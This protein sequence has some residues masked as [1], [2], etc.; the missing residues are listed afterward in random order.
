MDN[1]RVDINLKSG[2]DEDANIPLQLSVR[3]HDDIIVRN[4][5]TDAEWGLEE[6]EANVQS[7]TAPNPIIPGK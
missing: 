6:R 3:F 1:H 7:F 2:K 4:T 5:C